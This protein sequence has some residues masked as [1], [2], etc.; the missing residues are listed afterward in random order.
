MVRVKIGCKLP[1][2]PTIE[3]GEPGDDDYRYYQ[4]DGCAGKAPGFTLVPK[5]VWDIWKRANAKLR[6]VMDGSIF[7]AK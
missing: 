1:H 2:G 3:V 7:E 4:L 5:D 6:Y